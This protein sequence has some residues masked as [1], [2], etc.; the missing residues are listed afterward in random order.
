MNKQYTY[1]IS[2]SQPYGQS[3]DVRSVQKILV[4]NYKKLQELQETLFEKELE[5]SNYSEA[6]EFLTKF[7][8]NK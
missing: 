8:V 1:T 5:Q 4:Q 2:W 7:R 3:I 6:K